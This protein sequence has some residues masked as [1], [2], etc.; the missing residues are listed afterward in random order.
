MTARASFAE[1]GYTAWSVTPPPNGTLIEVINETT[2]Q[3]QVTVSYIV[4]EIKRK[5]MWWKVTGI[6]RELAGQLTLFAHAQG[7]ADI[8]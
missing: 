7:N 8:C 6:G 3:K 5:L 1:N 4:P 2:M